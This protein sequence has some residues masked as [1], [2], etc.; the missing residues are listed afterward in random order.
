[1]TQD[2]LYNQLLSFNDFNIIDKR[3]EKYIGTISGTNPSTIIFYAEIN[4]ENSTWICTFYAEQPMLKTK[5][6]I[7]NT[8]ESYYKILTESKITLQQLFNQLNNETI[9]LPQISQNASSSLLPSFELISGTWTG[10]KNINKIVLLRSGKGFVIF[11][12]GATMHI[13]IEITADNIICTQTG[14]PNASFFPELP[15]EIALV[16]AVNAKPIQW[17]LTLSDDKTLVGTK[18]TLKTVTE[19]TTAIGAEISTTQVSWIKQ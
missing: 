12:N 3:T 18:Q 11:N 14:K 8:Y 15:R 1:M 19:G 16:A 4:E 2:L 6:S 9:T 5:T 13:A 10:E 7:T 17:I